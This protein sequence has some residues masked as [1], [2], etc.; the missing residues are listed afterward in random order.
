MAFLEWLRK[1][2]RV[3]LKFIIKAIGWKQMGLF[4]TPTLSLLGFL[5][6]LLNCQRS[7]EEFPDVYAVFTSPFEIATERSIKSFW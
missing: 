5:L 3:E 1:L 4:S 2:V 7:W 6:T